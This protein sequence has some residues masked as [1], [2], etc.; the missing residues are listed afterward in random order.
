MRIKRKERR[1]DVSI[2]IDEMMIII[3]T[4]SLMTR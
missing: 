1:I 4:R 3:A 2:I